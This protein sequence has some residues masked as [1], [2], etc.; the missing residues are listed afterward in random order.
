MGTS[1]SINGKGSITRKTA[2]NTNRKY[3][4]SKQMAKV[5]L[6]VYRRIRSIINYKIVPLKQITNLFGDLYYEPSEW[7]DVVPFSE[8]NY[9]SFHSWSKPDS[10]DRSNLSK[11]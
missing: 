7:I 8:C 5:A 3:S 6:I 11:L 2:Y 1:L 4:I 10:L 9:N